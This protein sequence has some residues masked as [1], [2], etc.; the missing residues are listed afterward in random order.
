MRAI[1]FLAL[2]RSPMMAPSISNKTTN[3]EHGDAETVNAVAKAQIGAHPEVGK[4]KTDAVDVVNDVG[5]KNLRKQTAINSPPRSN[6][7]IRQVR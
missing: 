7:N 6:A 2:Q 4:G 5:K 3:V 1:H